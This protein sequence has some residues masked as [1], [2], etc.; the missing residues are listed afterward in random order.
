VHAS[1]YYIEAE[2]A[3]IGE[4]LMRRRKNPQGLSRSEGQSQVIIRYAT[5]RDLQRIVEISEET[6]ELENYTGQVMSASD[7][8]EFLD[9][10]PSRKGWA[11]LIVA[12]VDGNVVGYITGYKGKRYFYLPYGA[13]DKRYRRK[14][15]AT[16]LM[17]YVEKLALKERKKYVFYSVFTSN[18]A[19]KRFSRKLGF[20]P[21]RTLV[22]YAKVLR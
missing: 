6:R 7:F 15:I 2:M 10:S 8:A 22:Q 20:R 17:Q 4:Y 21:G 19:M 11:F 3:N 13:V 1:L 14:G 12:E 9:R 16:A 5:S 18:K